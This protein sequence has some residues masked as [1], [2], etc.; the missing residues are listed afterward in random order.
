MN[1]DVPV[2]ADKWDKTEQE[3]GATVLELTSTLAN[4][5]LTGLPSIGRN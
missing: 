1:D 5:A 2:K 4:L 3:T